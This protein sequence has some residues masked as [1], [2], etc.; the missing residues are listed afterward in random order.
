MRKIII[1]EDDKDLSL[2]I[3]AHFKDEGFTVE[4]AYNGQ[5]AY[6]VLLDSNPEDIV[7]LDI[8][9]PIMTGF[10]VLERLQLENR[11]VPLLIVCSKFAQQSDVDRAKEFGAVDY[12]MK[13]AV[14]PSEIVNKVKQIIIDTEAG[15]TI[16]GLSN[17]FRSLE[18]VKP[19][20]EV[21]RPG[22]PNN[23]A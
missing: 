14:S 15:L 1:I 13:A 19:M 4:N 17:T 5:E 12:I 20:A 3:T 7:L 22:Q 21:L 18:D 9:M 11:P 16:E 2:T 23:N 6:E 10:E 8:M